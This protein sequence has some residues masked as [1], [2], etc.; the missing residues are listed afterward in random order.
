MKRVSI[1]N[2]H[3]AYATHL[4]EAGLNL[5][6]VQELLGHQ[7]PGTTA[8]NVHM[9]DKTRDHQRQLIDGVMAQLRNILR[10]L[11]A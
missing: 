10:G 11:Q 1:H 3:H 6:S 8:R 7:S 9:T 5:R 4:I 2:L